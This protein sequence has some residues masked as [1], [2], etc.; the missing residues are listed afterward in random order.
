M[1]KIINKSKQA[2]FFG[3]ARNRKRFKMQS[4]TTL[5]QIVYR[6][7]TNKKTNNKTRN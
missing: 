4:K 1:I 2:V 6:I 7:K 3:L 5:I